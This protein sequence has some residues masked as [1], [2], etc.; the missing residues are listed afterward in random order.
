[1]AALIICHGS[2]GARPRGEGLS[3]NTDCNWSQ[4]LYVCYSESF[5]CFIVACSTA[6]SQTS[7]NAI[8]V[9]LIW[10]L[11]STLRGSASS[12]TSCT[13]LGLI[14]GR[15]TSWQWWPRLCT[16]RWSML[17]TLAGSLSRLGELPPRLE[18]WRWKGSETLDKAC[19]RK[20][21]I[22]YD[23]SQ[24]TFP[25]F[26]HLSALT[27]VLQED[28]LPSR[29]ILCIPAHYRLMCPF[30]PPILQGQAWMP[31]SPSIDI[32]IATLPPSA[33]PLCPES[34]A[35]PIDLPF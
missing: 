5:V 20:K 16:C 3:I 15:A 32:I 35:C 34:L 13:H 9:W 4:I 29:Y 6:S 31:V 11:R 17:W 19:I 14:W 33:L 18:P 10:I 1:M 23:M 22:L 8:L 2:S 12:W 30:L 21:I 25:L 27:L 7:W 24:P 26:L 28:L